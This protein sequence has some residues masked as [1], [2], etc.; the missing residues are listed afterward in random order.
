M[1]LT[2]RISMATILTCGKEAAKASEATHSNG[3]QPTSDGLHSKDNLDQST[4]INMFLRCHVYSEQT[5]CSVGKRIWAKGPYRHMLAHCHPV[6]HSV[7]RCHSTGCRSHSTSVVRHSATAS[8][9]LI[10]DRPLFPSED[11]I[12][13]GS[14]L[15]CRP[16]FNILE[17]S[18]SPVKSLQLSLATGA[19]SS[20]ACCCS[21]SA[22]RWHH[23]CN[24]DWSI[25]RVE[26][27]H[28]LLLVAM[29]I[30]PSSRARSP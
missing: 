24:M 7:T 17:R 26:D 15:M 4:G 9:S 22:C 30:A 14:P 12:S 8:F 28:S 19:S 1:P 18:Q 11:G 6:T 25:S 16:L 5:A 29:P 3:L 27:E 10:P 23:R 20:E 2:W 21:A 13:M